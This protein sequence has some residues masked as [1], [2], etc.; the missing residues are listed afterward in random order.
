MNFLCGQLY[1]LLDYIKA[2]LAAS[3]V[4]ERRWSS[5]RY[6]PTWGQPYGQ[7]RVLMRLF[8]LPIFRYQHHMWPN[9]KLHS[10]VLQIMYLVLCNF[11]GG[12]PR[13]TTGRPLTR[14]WFVQICE[15]GGLAIIRERTRAPS[16]IW[17][18]FIE[19][20]PTFMK[21]LR[22]H[23]GSCGLNL[24]LFFRVYIWWLCVCFFPKAPL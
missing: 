8:F 10:T 24:D 21:H 18:E 3:S 4:N 22:E 5:T 16:Q 9:H 19:Q 17:I 23:P 2:T 14:V 13:P 7:S 20:S 6:C 11:T 12:S 15:A 1:L